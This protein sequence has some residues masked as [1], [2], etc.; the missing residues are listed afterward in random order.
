MLHGSNIQHPARIAI[1]REEMKTLKTIAFVA[2]MLGSAVSAHATP[3]NLVVNGDFSNPNVGGGWASFSNGQVPG[4]TNILNND[5]IEID[6]SAILGGPAYPGTT[7]SAELN[8]NTFDWISQTISGLTVGKQYDLSWAYGD[9]PGSG[10]QRMDAYFGGN[11]LASN[12]GTGNNG[13]LVWTANK[14]VV[15]ATSSTEALTFRAINVGGSTGAGNEITAVSL[16]ASEVPEPAS[17]ALLS[18]GL[19]GMGAILRRKM[20]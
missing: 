13:G 17:I 14:F 1:E 16:T 4:W 11:L 19:A 9:R 6:H 20:K 8:G 18:L 15:T 10:S 3:V 2:A 5:G 12:F 7:Q